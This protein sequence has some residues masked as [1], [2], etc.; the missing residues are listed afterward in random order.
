MHRQQDLSE[1]HRSH[2]Q[3]ELQRGGQ[4]PRARQKLSSAA[5]KNGISAHRI[6][7]LIGA[8][9]NPSLTWMQQHEARVSVLNIIAID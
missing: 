3:P 5:S 4:T 2:K 9:T 6:A 8:T 7:G 1:F